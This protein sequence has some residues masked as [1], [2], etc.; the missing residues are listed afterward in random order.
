MTTASAQRWIQSSRIDLIFFSWGWLP[1]LVLFVAL[2]LAGWEDKGQS[3]LIV[4]ILL[5]NFLHRHL[6]FPLVYG[7]PEQLKRRRAA[8]FGLPLFFLVLTVFCLSMVKPARMESD[9]VPAAFSLPPGARLNVH[10]QGP[11]EK[12]P[13]KVLFSGAEQNAEQA[14]AAF[15]R[16]LGTRLEVSVNGD[17]LVFQIPE[18]SPDTAFRFSGV[19][20]NTAWLSDLG[21]KTS[22]GRWIRD[23][24]PWFLALVVVSVLWTMYHTVMQKVGLLRVYSRKANWGDAWLDKAAIFSWFVYVFCQS[25]A[26]ESVRERVRTLAASGRV[27]HSIVQPMEA[28]LWIPAVLSLIVSLILTGLYVKKEAANPGGFNAPKNLFFLSVLGLYGVFF[29]DL[30]VG[31]AVMGFSHAIEYLAFVNIFSR[32]KYLAKPA[33]SSLLARAVRRQAAS[34]AFFAL[35]LLAVFFIWRGYSR[36]TL[37]WYIV[38]SSFLHFIYDGWIWKVRQPE[39]GRPLGLNY[40]APAATQ[41]I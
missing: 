22:W 32:K 33:D 26:M 39:V 2:N 19:P 5:F 1:V 21:L 9:P 35:T 25:A 28:W 41:T 34:F 40:E 27:L 24:R 3:L 17:R 18:G 11:D 36:T 16:T 38:G 30:L 4:A 8:Y 14:A 7:D 12:K 23:K 6:T 31:Y 37:Q 10:F 29:Y 15:H 13:V 20:A